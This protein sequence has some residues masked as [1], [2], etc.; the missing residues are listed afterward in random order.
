MS[1]A[2]SGAGA[3]EDPAT[4]RSHRWLLR[5]PTLQDAKT[6]A[7][8]SV[9]ADEAGRWVSYAVHPFP[10]SAVTTWWQRLDV[11]PWLLIDPDG[12]PAGYGEIW[13]DADEDEVELARLIVDPQ[14]RRQ[15]VGTLLVD[16]LLG[17][18]RRSG[19]ANCF[20][21]VAP[22][23]TAALALYRTAG[24]RDVDPSQAAAWNQQQPLDY[25]WLQQS[26]SA[27]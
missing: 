25:A 1:T 19:R 8:W 9:S 13:D 17:L 16:Q 6:V 15:S 23:N 5:T 7:G 10:A 2:H 27:R 24:F 3:S 20:L 4:D 14:R 11:Q 18:A 26:L 22:G 12:T 21:R